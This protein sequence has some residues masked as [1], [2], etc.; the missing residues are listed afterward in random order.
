[1]GNNIINWNKL[2]MSV[3][4]EDITEPLKNSI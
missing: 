2:T 1:M 4:T 3:D